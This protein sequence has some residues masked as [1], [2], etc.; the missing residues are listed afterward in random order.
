MLSQI[1]TRVVNSFFHKCCDTKKFTSDSFTT[2]EKHLNEFKINLVL[3][4]KEAIGIKPTNEDQRKNIG[5][6]KTVS[7][8]ASK[9]CNTLLE[10]YTNQ[11]NRLH[12]NKKKNIAIKNRPET[13]SLKGFFC[14][15]EDDET[16]EGDKEEIDDISSMPPLEGDEEFV[17]IQPIVPLEIKEEKGLKILTPNKLLIR[18]TVFLAQIK[19][20]N[21]SYKLKNEIR[22]IYIF[23]INTIKSLKRFATI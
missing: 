10:I 14:F 11:F 12:K 7:D 13:F 17:D 20:G 3:F 9:L 15:S 1:C 5:Y 2:K 16:L 22:Q 23:C 4:Y 6:R 8:K 18:L 19:A 21:N